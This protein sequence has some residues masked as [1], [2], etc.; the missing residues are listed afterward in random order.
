MS[1]HWRSIAAVGSAVLLTAC[2]TLALDLGVV[3]DRPEGFFFVPDTADV[4]EPFEVVV[5]TVGGCGDRKG[6]TLVA[7]SDRGA[8]IAPFDWLGGDCLLDFQA[9][10]EHRATLKFAA[11][12]EVQVM[13]R[14]RDERTGGEIELTQ[15]VVIR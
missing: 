5:V 13:L 4:D 8:G 6:T 7:L 14:A 15:T 10:F 3:D 1:R 12:G 11:A 9:I 2:D